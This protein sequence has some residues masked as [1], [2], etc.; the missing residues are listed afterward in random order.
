MA[1]GVD[2]V[3]AAELTVGLGVGVADADVAVGVGLLGFALL[4][5][6]PLVAGACG[7]KRLPA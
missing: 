1:A 6:A 3:G 7:E 4:E 5:V 2:C